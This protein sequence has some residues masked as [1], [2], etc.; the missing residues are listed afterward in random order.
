M[1][2]RKDW[3]MVSVAILPVALVLLHAIFVV[4]GRITS[5]EEKLETQGKA[6]E[7]FQRT[8]ARA[9]ENQANIK[10]LEA[11]IEHIEEQL[12][13]IAWQL[14]DMKASIDQSFT[15]LQHDQRLILD[16]LLPRHPPSI[17]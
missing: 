12:D 7:G 16:H 1:L 14:A 11:K 5:I 17:P 3:I 4:G 9:T 2:N 10:V 6:I 15:E 8:Q 13:T